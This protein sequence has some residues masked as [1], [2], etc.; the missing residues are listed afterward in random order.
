MV[1]YAVGWRIKLPANTSTS[2]RKH[3]SNS[4]IPHSTHPPK[5]IKVQTSTRKY[6]TVGKDPQKYP[7]HPG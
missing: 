2:K 7:D 6:I 5:R 3:Q 4:N 1:Q